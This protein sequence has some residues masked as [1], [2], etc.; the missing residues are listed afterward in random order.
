MRSDGAL[1]TPIALRPDLVEQSCRHV[2]PL[3]LALGKMGVGM[4]RAWS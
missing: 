2:L 3:A 4:D 1:F